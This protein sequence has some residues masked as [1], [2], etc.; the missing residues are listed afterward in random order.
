ME[1]NANKVNVIKVRFKVTSYA[2]TSAIKALN[3][4]GIYD[5][6]VTKE[7]NDLVVVY[8]EYEPFRYPKTDNNENS[9]CSSNDQSFNDKSSNDKCNGCKH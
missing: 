1:E 9:D 6:S 8:D 2:L 7:D 3:N 5:I 4:C